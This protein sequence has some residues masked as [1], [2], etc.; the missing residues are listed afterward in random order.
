MKY[1]KICQNFNSL[2]F[3]VYHLFILYM[4]VPDGLLNVFDEKLNILC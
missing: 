4:C 3:V 2:Y 1:A